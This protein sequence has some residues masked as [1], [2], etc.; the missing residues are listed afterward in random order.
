M[1]TDNQNGTY[2]HIP[3]NI[4]EEVML[5]PSRSLHGM[6]LCRGDLF[7]GT[8]PVIAH[9]C[10]LRGVMGA[11]VAK[12]MK[13]RFPD[14]FDR[15]EAMCK[16]KTF[17][18]GDMLVTEELL[19]NGRKIRIYNLM[20]QSG[21]EGA[22]INFLITAMHNMLDDAAKNGIKEITMPLIGGGLGGINPSA[23]LNI[24]MQALEYTGCATTLKVIVQYVAGVIPE[25]ILD[26]AND[27][28]KYF[29]KHQAVRASEK[30]QNAPGSPMSLEEG[31]ERLPGGAIMRTRELTGEELKRVQEHFKI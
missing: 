22:D 6:R 10:N 7:A 12:Q 26:N 20:T 11:G 21:F 31:T 2:P 3:S 25:P 27:A 9:G 15:Y 29:K 4:S 13:I 24:Y 1:C 18:G 19:G 5:P 23:C 28:S 17:L 30:D 14:T 8:S 16:D